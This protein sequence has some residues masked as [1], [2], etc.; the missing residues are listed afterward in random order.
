MGEAATLERQPPAQCTTIGLSVGTWFS[1]A[2][3]WASGTWIAPG[4]VPSSTSPGLRMSTSVT[5]SSASRRSSSATLIRGAA[6]HVPQLGGKH[7]VPVDGEISDGVVGADAGQSQRRVLFFAGVGDQRDLVPDV[8]DHAAGLGETTVEELKPTAVAA[9]TKAAQDRGLSSA[10]FVQDDITKF[11]GF[12]GRFNT[13]I[14]STL[15]HS[16]PVEGRDGYLRSVH[17]A[18]APGASYYIL[19]FAKGAVPAELEQKPNEVDEDELREAVSKYW[20]IDEIRPA[21]IHAKVVPT[22]DLPF[23]MPPHDTDDKGRVVPGVPAHPHKA[24]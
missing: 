1:R 13:V 9:A 20:Q 19:V 14:D 8:R 12:D 16:P 21:F 24:G 17:R 6:H 10:T 5:A 23:E 18:A 11:T 22:P 4:M 3:S 7:P 15:F 2:R